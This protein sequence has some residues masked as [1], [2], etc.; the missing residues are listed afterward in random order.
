MADLKSGDI[1]ILTR[2]ST[3]LINFSAQLINFSAQLI[4]FKSKK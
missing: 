2:V 4:N 1:L 3:Q